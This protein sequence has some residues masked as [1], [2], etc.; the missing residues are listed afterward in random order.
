[1]NFTSPLFHTLPATPLDIVGDVHGEFETLMR[2]LHY[3][4]YDDQGHHPQGRKLVFVGDLCDRGQ[5]SPSVLQWVLKAIAGERAFAVLGNHELNLLMN[6]PKDGSGWYFD[7]RAQDEQRYAPWQHFPKDKRNALH[8]ALTQWPLVLQRDDI[9]VVHAAWLPESLKQIS[10][11]GNMPIIQ[12]YHYWEDEFVRHFRQSKW[13][14]DYQKEQQQRLNIED[15]QTPMTFQ[16]GMAHHDLLRSYANPIRVVTSG[17]EALA[18]APF[19]AGGHWRFTVR[20]PWWLQYTE[21]SRVVIGHYWRSWYNDPLPIHRQGLF[22]EPSTQ[23]L[24]N[25]RRVFCVD[26]SVGARW[27]E[28]Q[29][30]IDLKQTRFHLAA[31]RWPEQMIVL[32]NGLHAATTHAE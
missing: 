29:R 22:H 30:G 8:E 18:P 26:F 10:A 19:Y 13:Y 9:R 11:V 4:G 28:R 20:M 27:R 16:P 32:D 23:W 15:E 5:D 21:K 6:D 14:A 2:L 24:G 31:L 12:Q 3:L 7:H 25:A 17:V 1:M